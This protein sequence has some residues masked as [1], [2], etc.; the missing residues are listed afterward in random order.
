MP[1]LIFI[2]SFI[3]CM[4]GANS[5][6]TLLS[7][8]ALALKKDYKNIQEALSQPDSVYCL[9]LIDINLSQSTLRF[10][11]FTNLQSLRLYNNQLSA[12]PGSITNLAYLQ[13]LS[14]YENNL[15]SLP[16]SIHKLVHLRKFEMNFNALTS[17]PIQI[18]SLVNLTEMDLR[19]NRL[20]SLP[21]ESRLLI[22]LQTLNLSGNLFSSFTKNWIRSLLPNCQIT[23]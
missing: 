17:I 2:V 14:I 20:N 12:L 4:L 10:D 13:E 15:T 16:S 11:T 3:F 5:Q 19:Y 7:P 6:T 8:S 23:F 18:G 9:S 22:H 1:R 21:Y